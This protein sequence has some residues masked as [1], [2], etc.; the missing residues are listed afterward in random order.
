MAETTSLSPAPSLGRN[1]AKASVFMIALRIVFRFIGLFNSLLLV[2]LLS[3]NDFGIVGMATAVSGALETVTNASLG[4]ALIRLPTMTRDHLDTAWT[5]QIIRGLILFA[6]MG[7]S[8]SFVADWM[9]DPRVE[10]IMWVLAATALTGGFDNIGVVAFGR[11]LQY[12]RVFELQLYAKLFS[13][14]VMLPIAFV[15]RSYWALIA[16]TVGMR[17]FATFYSYHIHPYRPALSLR[18]GRELFHFSKWFVLTN[19]LWVIDQFTATFLFG[20]IGGARAVGLY[21]VAYQVASLPASEIAAPIRDPIYS[22]YARA[23]GDKAKLRQQFVDG[24]AV[25][26][27]VIGPMSV[28]IA[29]TAD[30]VSPVALG[31]QWTDASGLLR[32]CAIYAF[33]DA[34]G[35]FPHNILIVLNRQRGFV[36]TFALM[37]TLRTPLVIAAG[38]TW[39]MEAAVAALALT[40]VIGA[41]VWMRFAM[42]L[43]DCRLGE[44]LMPV[45]RTIASTVFMTVGLLTFADLHA[46]SDPLSVILLRLAVISLSGAALQ[47]GTQ[48]LLWWLCGMPEGPETQLL[49]MLRS[50]LG[51][52]SGLRLRRRNA[53]AG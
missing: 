33:V 22:G 11:D 20:R 49:G 51:R 29:L 10:L 44:L 15:F 7:G 26:M 17:L 14:A 8:A 34:I 46:G 2:R 18:R 16:G 25:L 6:L 24:F 38:T 4:L 31:W 47:I 35:H 32:L 27:L 39:G 19:M 45:W 36:I 48:A 23:M 40:G 21:Q 50:S 5:F 9:G 42:P 41:V 3:P 53:P 13:L 52:L 1:V 12:G 30:L 28:G 37:L 43:I